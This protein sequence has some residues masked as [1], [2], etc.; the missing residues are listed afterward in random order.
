METT[1][2]LLSLKQS[3]A[4]EALGEEAFQNSVLFLSNHTEPATDFLG[5]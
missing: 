2:N 1:Y 5:S 4:G 3:S